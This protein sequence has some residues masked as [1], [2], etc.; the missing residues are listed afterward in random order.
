MIA[1]DWGT[2]TLRIYRLDR[3]GNVLET[4]SSSKGILAVENAKFA[5][6]L[7]NEAG[8]WID[9][10]ESPI[11][12]SGMI[13]SRQGWAEAAYAECPAGFE[14]IAGAM[15][16]VRWGPRR[17]WIAPGVCCRDES[18]VRDVMRGEEVQ[19]LGAMD[20]LPDG[21]QVICLPGTHSKWVHVRDRKIERFRTY[22]T[23]EVFAVLKAH[24]ILGRMIK[25]DGANDA[26]FDS[27]VARSGE[28]DGLLHHL[29]GVRARGLFGELDEAQSASYLSGILIGHEL[30]SA[31]AALRRIHLLC[32]PQL[33]AIYT[34]A[35][36]ALGIEAVALEPSSVTRGLFRLANLIPDN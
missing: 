35:A 1:I 16:E 33:A 14:T 30:R 32:N 19:I 18:G 26:A 23:G 21:D 17:G 7:E 34:R 5:E 36:L 20:D 28:P 15:R 31:A 29:F 25:D 22:M 11:V 13:G 24:S 10:G 3:D 9:A 27:G 2:S 4:R 6:A 12:M 8:D